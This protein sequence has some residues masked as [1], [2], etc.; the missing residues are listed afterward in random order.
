MIRAKNY[1]KLS[2][3]VKVVAKKYCWPFFSGHSV[4]VPTMAYVVNHIDIF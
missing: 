3:C 2:K 1:I 4:H